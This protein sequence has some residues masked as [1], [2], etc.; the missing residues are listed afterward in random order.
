MVWLYLSLALLLIAGIAW[1]LHYAVKVEPHRVEITRHE[2]VFPDLPEELDGL[3]ICQVSDMHLTVPARNEAAITEAVRSVKADLYA[4]TGDMIYRQEGIVRFF[5]WLD[6][7]GDAVR[8]AVAILGNA[9]HKRYVKC[10]E[11]VRGLCERAVPLLNNDC[12][13]L[14]VRDT[15]I[16]IVGVDDPHTKHHDFRTAYADAC[17]NRW[18]L[19]LCHSPDG[20]A[21][22]GGL[23]ADLI[24]CGHTHGGQVRLPV[25]GALVHGTQRLK[26]LVMGW[27]GGKVLSRR[28]RIPLNGAKMYVSRGLGMSRFPMR[29]LCRP[30]LAVFTLRKS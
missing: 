30:E 18:T 19:L 22:L 27:Y 23:R 10:E 16:Q 20:A 2:V 5:Q 12:Q 1:L 13:V 9:E 7:M 4:F 8:P 21:D 17:P 25:I 26:G 29:L 11:V 6:A 24:L 3:T 15:E 28:A 14:S